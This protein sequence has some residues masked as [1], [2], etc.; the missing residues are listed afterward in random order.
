MLEYHYTLGITINGVAL[1]DPPYDGG[2]SFSVADL[3]ISAERD[4]TGKL[5]RDRVAT[6]IN[7][8]FNYNLIGWDKAREILAAL[9]D[10]EFSATILTFDG[11]H[12][13]TYYCGDRSCAPIWLPDGTKSKWITSLKF[14][15]IE[16]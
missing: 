1:P 7:A 5:H 13:G 14:N 3:D 9:G 2:Y 12:S 10:A 4:T 8:Q 11:T 6:K 15:I 16:Y